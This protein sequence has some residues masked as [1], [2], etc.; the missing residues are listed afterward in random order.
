[1][2]F[3][4]ENLVEH[5]PHFNIDQEELGVVLVVQH[6]RRVDQGPKLFVLGHFEKENVEEALVDL[7]AAVILFDEHN[8]KEAVVVAVYS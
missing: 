2:A 8:P 4:P 5:G 7:V 3:R 6:Q 1:M